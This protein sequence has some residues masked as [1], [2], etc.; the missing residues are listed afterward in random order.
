M[1]SISFPKAQNGGFAG[2]TNLSYTSVQLLVNN[3]VFD[4]TG[5]N[6]GVADTFKKYCLGFA[7]IDVAFQATIRV[8]GACSKSQLGSVDPGDF[9]MKPQQVQ[10][11]RSWPL[12]DVTGSGDTEKNWEWGISTFAANVRGKV[13][14]TGPIYNDQETSLT[15]DIDSVG[16]FALTG[17]IRSTATGLPFN[18]G[19]PFP[20]SFSALGNGAWVLTPDG[21]NFTSTMSEN[22]TDP[23][24]DE[25]TIDLDTGETITHDAILYQL[26][27]S[28][29]MENGG[30]VFVNGRFRFDEATA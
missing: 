10:I 24:K 5:S 4:T 13:I 17:T 21:T 28:Q 18:R 12:I 27:F 2:L 6:A 30:P 11:A 14:A 23:W 1:A 19:G 8:A 7:T 29:D 15:L 26:S 20:F 25:I 9:E 22:V 16:S 3:R